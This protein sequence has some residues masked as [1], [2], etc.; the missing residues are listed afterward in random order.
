MLARRDLQ[1]L[2]V[3][4]SLAR[5]RQSWRSILVNADSSAATDEGGC[6][7]PLSLIVPVTVSDLDA[8][9]LS[10]SSAS[11]HRARL[12]GEHSAQPTMW[13]LRM[14]STRRVEVVAGFRLLATPP[15][16][17]VAGWPSSARSSLSNGP[18]RSPRRVD[19][20]GRS[21]HAEHHTVVVHLVIVKPSGKLLQRRTGV[22]RG[23]G[24]E[25]F[26][27]R[28]L[29]CPSSISSAATG[30][31]PR[32]NRRE[33]PSTLAVSRASEVTESA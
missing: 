4:L 5:Y 2:K 20:S 1:Y 32:P 3:P 16:Q 22:E 9:E 11:A 10:A 6:A 31:R 24:Q 27:D 12:D 23:I 26:R 13:R 8:A 25:R 17:T 30:S 18:R 15:L 7:K 33:G 21:E 28:L 19:S 14:S 29:I